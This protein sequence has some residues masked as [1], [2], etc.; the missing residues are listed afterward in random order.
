[1]RPY[2]WTPTAARSATTH[3]NL[4]ARPRRSASASDDIT[5]SAVVDEFVEAA[6]SGHAL[7]R[8][9]RPYRPS[10]LR[11]LRGILEYHVIPDLGDARLRG[12]RRSDVQTL[13]D[14]LGADGL[15]ESRIRS[16]VSALR[17]LYGYAIEQGH[18]EF[19]PA[20]GLVMPRGGEPVRGGVDE[21]PDDPPE[22][23]DPPARPVA[24]GDRDG[25]RQREPSWRGE[26]EP[27]W[28]GER[29]A[30]G[31]DRREPSRPGQRERVEYEP[32]A[33]LPERMLSFALRAVFVLFAL[34]ALVSLLESL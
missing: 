25:R 2:D 28:R 24:K 6:E 26:R 4:V 21:L 8:S 32:I 23:E 3:P 20:D 9:G 19:N 5:V 30:S 16:V 7:N 15:S 10:A 31:H 14:R 17:A 22:S 29:E 33:P 11:D 1:L 27:S 18:V 12:V 13:V 34:V